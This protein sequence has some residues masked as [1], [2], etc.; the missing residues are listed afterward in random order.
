[1]ENRKR[2][3]H[4]ALALLGE[5]FTFGGGGKP[6]PGRGEEQEE[7]AG[8]DTGAG[9]G[10]AAK[11]WATKYEISKENLGHVFHIDGD[12]GDA[13]LG[14]APGRNDKER[15]INSYILAGLAEFLRT[16]DAK[17]TD[18]A[19]RDICRKLG[20]YDPNNHSVYIKRPGNILSGNK[21]SGW[22]LT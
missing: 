8:D 15:A 7:G 13:I 17:F 21:D 19:A 12:K 2:A 1:S 11:R 10:T 20:C 16:G 3:I 9:L 4:S 22:T 5:T 18:K 6:K 14:H